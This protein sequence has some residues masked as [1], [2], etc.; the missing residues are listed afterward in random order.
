M[1]GYDNF[2][3]S[4]NARAAYADGEK[5]LSKWTKTEILDAI[6]DKSEIAKKL[7]LDELRCELLMRSSWHHTG[8]MYNCTDFYEIDEEAAEQLTTAR[9]AEIIEQRKPREKKKAEQTKDRH[10]RVRFT[11]WVG[12]YRN[13]HRPK[14]IEEIVI[15]PSNGGIVQTSE[16]AKRQSSLTILEWLD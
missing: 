2:S 12:N 6:G 7:T 3:M 13:Y 10:A 9:V 4:N 1:A 16:G 15:I 5:P 14:E 11:V 8:K